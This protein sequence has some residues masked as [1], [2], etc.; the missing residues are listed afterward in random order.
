MGTY[1]ILRQLD[2]EQERRA[3]IRREVNKILDITDEAKRLRMAFGL[4]LRVNPRIEVSY[5]DGT[6][7]WIPAQQAFKETL[8]KIKFLKEIPETKYGFK[9]KH[10]YAAGDHGWRTLMEFP[11]GFTE[12]IQM[13]AV[14]LFKGSGD[15]QKKATFRLAKIFPE[16]VVPEAL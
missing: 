4:W 15:E 9:K 8:D 2:L 13:F 16:F 1:S 10:W 11:P 14:S 5:S 6:E 12:F 3:E 7:A